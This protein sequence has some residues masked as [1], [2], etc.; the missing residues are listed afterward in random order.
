MKTR[1]L[2]MPMDGRV[3]SGTAV[4]IVM[5]M[6][7]LAFGWDDRP[8]GEYLDWLKQQM[9]LQTGAEIDLP[10]GDETTTCEALVDAMVEHGLALEM[11]R[12]G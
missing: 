3:F 1:R 8:L 6:R 10:T 9:Q 2:R 5:Q 4:D 7:L 12:K 11:S